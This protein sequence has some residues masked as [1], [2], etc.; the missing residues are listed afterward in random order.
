MLSSKFIKPL[1]KRLE[2]HHFSHHNSAALSLEG[3]NL[4]FTYK[5]VLSFDE[6]EREHEIKVTQ[7]ES[8]SS[9]SIQVQEVPLSV[10]RGFVSA[11]DDNTSNDC[12]E[13]EETAS[14][15]LFTH[16]GEFS[17]KHVE[18]RHKVKLS[19]F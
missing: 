7:K 14:V 12:Q 16:F 6:S 1:V 18:V 9:R 10:P 4:C 19:Y 15:R 8:I 5:F 11:T 2:I 17:F 13:C 3:D